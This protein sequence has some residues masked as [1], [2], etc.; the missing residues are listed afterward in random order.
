VPSANFFRR[1]RRPT[2]LEPEIAR[3]YAR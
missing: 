2:L 1:V 3:P